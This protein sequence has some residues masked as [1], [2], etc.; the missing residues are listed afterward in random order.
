MH[1][2]HCLAEA[3]ISA[4]QNV[5]D[6]SGMSDFD[7]RI[8]AQEN[9]FLPMADDYLETRLQTCTCDHFEHEEKRSL[10][11]DSMDM[12]RRLGD[13]TIISGEYSLDVLREQNARFKQRVADLECER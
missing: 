7:F 5:R 8:L 3:I 13:H 10:I 1:R 9:R 12:A 6:E 11:L 2:R 4:V